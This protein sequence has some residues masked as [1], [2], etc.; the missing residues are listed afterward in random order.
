MQNWLRARSS[1]PRSLTSPR[2]WLWLK[3]VLLETGS[4]GAKLLA[5][6]TCFVNEEVI[7]TAEALR[8][9]SSSYWHS[10]CFKE[11]FAQLCMGWERKGP[12]PLGDETAG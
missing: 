7:S 8:E 12:V 6:G 4:P 2:G 5:E 3:A 9:R 1:E 11:N 10:V